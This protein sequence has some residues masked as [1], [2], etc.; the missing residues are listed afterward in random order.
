M[1]R[2][3]PM[4]SW[5]GQA[6]GLFSIRLNIQ[7]CSIAFLQHEQGTAERING[8]NQLQNKLSLNMVITPVTEIR[9][10]IKEGTQ[11]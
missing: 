2:Q 9:T 6:M 5:Q 7:S 8:I 10:L 3:L 1:D 11:R 4:V